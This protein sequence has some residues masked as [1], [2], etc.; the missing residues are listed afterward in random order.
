MS[1]T[2]YRAKSDLGEL[3]YVGITAAGLARF[4]EHAEQKPWWQ[5][6]AVVELEHHDTREAAAAAE[7]EAIRTECPRYNIIHGRHRPR[8]SAGTLESSEAL[9]E[10]TDIAVSVT[11]LEAEL[12]VARSERNNAIETALDLG[13][14]QRRIAELVGLSHGRIG[15]I[16]TGRG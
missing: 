2:L 16:A 5:D 12:E 11:E 15:Q 8:A 14:P 10:L 7:V 6:V 1:T 4:R 3:L 9:A 13:L